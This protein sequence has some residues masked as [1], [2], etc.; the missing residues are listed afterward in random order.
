MAPRPVALN[1]SMPRSK[2]DL[3]TTED[4]PVKVPNQSVAWRTVQKKLDFAAEDAKPSMII[5][6]IVQGTSKPM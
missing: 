5:T 6:L 1:G 2:L 4:M 3:T